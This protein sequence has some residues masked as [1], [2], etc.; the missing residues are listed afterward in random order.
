M[1]L[2]ERA[3]RQSLGVDDAV[4]VMSSTIFASRGGLSPVVD[5][6]LAPICTPTGA[7]A[8]R[9]SFTGAMLPWNLILIRRRRTPDL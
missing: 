7:R 6:I 4:G 8:F 2:A 1:Q 5:L 3:E 9:G